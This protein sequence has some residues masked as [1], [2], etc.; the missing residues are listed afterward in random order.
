MA[1]LGG[2]YSWSY[3]PVFPWMAYPLLG[4]AFYYFKEELLSGSYSITRR[5]NIW[6]V[7]LSFIIVVITGI[8]PFFQTIDLPR[9]YHH[10]WSY[11][12]WVIGFLCWYLSF[13]M[14]VNDLLK[15]NII[16]KYV[17]WLGKNVTVIYVL[18]WLIIGNIATEIYQSQTLTFMFYWFIGVLSLVSILTHLYDRLMTRF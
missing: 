3:F 2:S 12:L 15:S 6:L 14:F 5:K 9:Y 10:N 17:H 16:M 8:G 18:Q 11:Y 1:F 4:Y 13:S 7:I